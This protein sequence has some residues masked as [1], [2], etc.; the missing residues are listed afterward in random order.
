MTQSGYPLPWYA[1]R[2]EVKRALD[3]K[4]P[5]IADL[6]IDRAIESASR[7]I[8]KTMGRHFYPFLDTRYFDWPAHQFEIP[9]RIW[10]DQ[11][12]MC[13]IPTAIT[14]ANGAQ[15]LTNS[16][17]Y[18]MRPDDALNR[19]VPFTRVEINLGS[20]AAFS[21]GDSHQRAVAITGPFGFSKAVD[22][23]GTIAADVSSVATTVSVSNSAMTGVGAL[24][25]LGSEYLHTTD[26]AWSA[27]AGTLAGNLTANNGNT[28]VP[29]SI[30][31]GATY[32][33][34]ELVTI[35]AE[36]MLITGVIGD[37]LIVRRAWNG[38]TLASHSTS[39]TIYAPRQLTV[40]R[41][42]L[43]T[44]A[45]AYSSGVQLN[46][47][48]PPS[49]I[50]EL[51]IAECVVTRLSE[52][53]GYSQEVGAGGETTKLGVGLADLWDGAFEAYG[54]QIRVRTAGRLI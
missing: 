17:D 7:M 21:S 54:R 12:E 13:G 2:E 45:A 19:G 22:V 3:Y 28:S 4:E 43:G 49:K 18:F 44:S 53:S 38:S 32:S 25:V 24:L 20:Q 39:A 8:D 6:D 42:V 40:T 52:T 46:R 37:T 23:V 10:L 27:T 26:T 5:A 16:I 1:T 35:D 34:L 48:H 29:V 50:K 51:C 11:N 31:S 9:W 14:V 15:T 30:G 47:H 33:K 41:A 36:T